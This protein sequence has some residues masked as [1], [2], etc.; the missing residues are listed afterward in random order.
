MKEETY[1]IRLITEKI[2]SGSTSWKVQSSGRKSLDNRNWELYRDPGHLKS[3]VTAA[4]VRLQEEGLVTIDWECGHSGESIEKL[5]FRLEEKDR[6]FERYRRESDPDFIP[7]YQKLQRYTDCFQTQLEKAR[8]PWIQTYYRELLKSAGKG[9]PWQKLARAEEYIPYFEGLDEISTSWDKSVFAEKY[10]GGA[11]NF[12]DSARSYVI[13]RAR[14]FC[15]TITEDMDDTEVLCGIGIKEHSQY[16]YLK[17]ELRIRLLDRSGNLQPVNTGVWTYGTVLNSETMEHMELEPVQPQIRRIIVFENKTNFVM[18][19]YEEGTLYLFG[20]GH[21]SPKEKAI[22]RRLYE[23]LE[24]ESGK[25]AEY[26]HSGD[27]DYGGIRIFLCEKKQVFPKLKPLQMDETTHGEFEQ[28]GYPMKP[29]T[30]KL[31]RN[32]EVEGKT[33]KALREKLLETSVGIEQ[34]SFLVRKMEE[35]ERKEGNI[36]YEINDCI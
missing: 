21:F 33:L 11:K 26:F 17:G 13:G 6:F 24:A 28:M 34:E 35:L 3:D 18:A 30:V 19:P 15:E 32:M 36:V 9:Q 20:H 7:K 12:T 14:Q 8:T 31:L 2:E 29:E 1:L 5:W 22:L 10:L 23:I 16:L 25:P 27:L 4:A